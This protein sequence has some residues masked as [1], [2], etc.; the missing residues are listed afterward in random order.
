VPGSRVVADRDVL[1][2]ARSAIE[3]LD[4]IMLAERKGYAVSK[5]VPRANRPLH[6]EA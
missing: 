3:P 4:V 2:P 5:F 1:K 6:A